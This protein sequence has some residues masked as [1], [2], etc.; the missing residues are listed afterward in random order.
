[1]LALNGNNTFFVCGCI[2]S[3]GDGPKIHVS[4]HA[5]CWGKVGPLLVEDDECKKVTH[6]TVDLNDSYFKFRL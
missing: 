5:D 4:T 2:V 3:N 6:K 1:M